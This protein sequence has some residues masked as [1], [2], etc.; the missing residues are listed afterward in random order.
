MYRG[1]QPKVPIF[2]KRSSLVA[3][4]QTHI[5]ITRIVH[6]ERGNVRNSKNSISR[7]SL[8]LLFLLILFI[9]NSKNCVSRAR[10]CQEFE[11]FDFESEFELVVSTF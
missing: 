11:E 7:A 4:N 1:R 3:V 2:K 8:N 10:K 5:R 9:K 6:L